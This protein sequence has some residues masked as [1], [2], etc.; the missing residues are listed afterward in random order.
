MDGVEDVVNLTSQNSFSSEPFVVS[1]YISGRH[2]NVLGTY[3]EILVGITWVSLHIV[4]RDDPIM[5]P[6]ARLLDP[7]RGLDVVQGPIGPTVQRYPV[8]SYPW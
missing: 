3:S 2:L 5:R 8:S 4:R 6:C 1:Q 7:K